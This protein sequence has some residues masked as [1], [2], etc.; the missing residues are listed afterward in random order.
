MQTGKAQG[1]QTMGNHMKYLVEKELVT[2]E[3]A[4]AY[5]RKKRNSCIHD[6]ANF[7]SGDVVVPENID[8]CHFL[9][10]A[11]ERNAIR[12]HVSCKKAQNSKTIW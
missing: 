1:M 3:E 2:K 12:T 8:S 6:N 11:R 7:L 9:I 4:A 5:L 10:T